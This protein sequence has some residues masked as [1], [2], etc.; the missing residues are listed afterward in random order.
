MR[1]LALNLNNVAHHRPECMQTLREGECATG[2]MHEGE[3]ML[4]LDHE[5]VVT[6]S[7]AHTLAPPPPLPTGQ[8]RAEAVPQAHKDQPMPLLKVLLPV[9]MVVAIGAV[10]ALMVMSGRTVSPM[11]LIFPVMMLFGMV[12][13]FS[14]QERQGDIDETRRVYLRHLDALAHRARSNAEVQREHAEYLHPA[15]NA[16][17]TAVPAERVWEPVSYTHLTLPTKA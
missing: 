5:P 2:E 11:M 1:D 15:P 9:V 7:T 13:M 6:P 16:L 12:T 3:C 8:L 14:P 10:M 17:L 4:G